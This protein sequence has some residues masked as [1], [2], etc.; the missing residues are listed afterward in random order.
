[1]MAISQAIDI[2]LKTLRGTQALTKDKELK[3]SLNI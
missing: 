3:K 1:M 2:N